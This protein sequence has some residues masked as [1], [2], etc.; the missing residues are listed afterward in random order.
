MTDRLLFRRLLAAIAVATVLT[1]GCTPDPVERDAGDDTDDTAE[2]PLPSFETEFTQPQPDAPDHSIEDRVVELLDQTP[3]DA[4]VL[5]AFYTFSR[6]RVA[7][8]FIDA[9]ERGVDVRIVLGN[10]NTFD[11]GTPW[12][13]VQL[14][15]DEL[16]DRLTICSEDEE[17]HEGG[18]MGDNIHHNKFITFSELDDGSE[19]LVLQT[20]ANLTSAQLEQFNNMVLTRGDSDLYSAFVS[21]W[22]DLQPDVTDLAYDR[23]EHGE[24]TKAYFFPHADG[25]PILDVLDEVRC[26]VETDIYL[27][28][29]FFTNARVPVA[30]QLRQ[31]DDDGCNVFVVLRERPE[32]FS[33]GDEIID[34]LE[35]GDINLGIFREDEEIQLHS[36]Y[37]AIDGGYGADDDSRVVWT[38]SHNYTWFALRNNDEVLLKIRD[39]DVFDAHRDDWI[40]IRN[41]AETLHP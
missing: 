34:E 9:Y 6:E 38:G 3:D 4:R 2:E 40:H 11:D 15:D 18:C 1:L 31:L 25:D 29:A 16:G 17:H 21:Y 19:D 13:A 32:V 24:Q 14:L 35:R 20:S 10:T 41:R 39:D 36:K 28:V 23:Y 7:Q 30:E 5:A 12:D 27:A 22:N 26:D 8:A 33:P 37:L